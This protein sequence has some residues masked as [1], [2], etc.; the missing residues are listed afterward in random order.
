MVFKATLRKV[1]KFWRVHLHCKSDSELKN[2]I[3]RKYGIQLFQLSFQLTEITAKFTVI[4]QAS[5]EMK[6]DIAVEK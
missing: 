3:K 2:S 1:S 5:Y 4:H 6:G